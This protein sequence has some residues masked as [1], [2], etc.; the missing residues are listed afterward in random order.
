M[1]TIRFLD[2]QCRAILA[3]DKVAAL[4]VE[5]E[6][7][8]GEVFAEPVKVRFETGG[9]AGLVS[10]ARLFH[11]TRER[12]GEHVMGPGRAGSDEKCDDV[13]GDQRTD[14]SG[15]EPKGDFDEN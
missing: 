12:P 6:V 11:L 4:C 9:S 8:V 2:K 1:R 5:E 3:S 7:F 10:P 15:E 14:E 13:E